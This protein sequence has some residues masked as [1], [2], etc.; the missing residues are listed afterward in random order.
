[1]MAPLLG[2]VLAVSCGDR[3]TTD[4][5]NLEENQAAVP[6]EGTGG[7]VSQPGAP[8]EPAAPPVAVG[9]DS[10]T[11]VPP[12]GTTRREAP[13]RSETGATRP[14]AESARTPEATSAAP[15]PAPAPARARFIERTIPAGTALPLEL[16]TALS[17]TTATVETPVSA[18][19]ANGVIIDGVTVLPAGTVFSGQVIDVQRPGRVEGRARLSI[20]F[21]EARVNGARE[22]IRTNPITFEGEATRGEDA[23]KIGAGAG[24]GAIIGGIAGGGDGAAKGAAIGGAAGTAAVLATRGRDVELASGAD[25]AATVATSATLQVEND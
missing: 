2:A 14:A 20:R 10:R 6:A 13:P 24:I 22:D 3:G 18:R 16:T 19:L 12:P 4:R 7:T 8:D 23:T 1:M 15:A 21:T 5:Q 25:L 9:E 11:T 17:S